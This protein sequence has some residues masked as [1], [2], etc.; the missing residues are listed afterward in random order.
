M[1]VF[2]QFASVEIWG[3]CVCVEHVYG[4]F[5]SFPIRFFNVNCIYLLSLN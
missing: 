1:V 4:L 2:L 5:G 3:W